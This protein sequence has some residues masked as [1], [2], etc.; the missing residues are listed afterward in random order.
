MGAEL[1][2]DSRTWQD[3]RGVEKQWYSFKEQKL[4]DIAIEWCKENNIPYK[5]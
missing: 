2:E 4:R 1:S 3:I 5:E